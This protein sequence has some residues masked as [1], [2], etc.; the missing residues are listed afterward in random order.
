MT[1]SFGELKI[2]L[3]EDNED[4]VFLFK[5]ALLDN[6]LDTEIEV[7][8]DGQA[9]IDYLIDSANER[10]DLM[11]LDL[12]MPRKN[13]I[14]VLQFVKTAHELKAIPVIVFTNSKNP[15]DIKK[16]YENFASCYINK[17]M[18]YGGLK[19]SVRRI[20]EYWSNLVE[21]PENK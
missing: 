8:K 16:S 4:E 17:P 2:L 11:M 9:A 21:F 18:T 13:G 10:P 20:E 6:G 19:Q 1:R 7:V 3:A 5:E 14:E 15:E 12:N